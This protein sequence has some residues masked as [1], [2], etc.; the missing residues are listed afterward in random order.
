LLRNDPAARYPE[1]GRQQVSGLFNLGMGGVARAATWFYDDPGLLDRIAAW[2][3]V[4]LGAG[5]FLLL[6]LTGTYLGG[7][8][9]GLGAC[10]VFLLFPGTSLDR[11]LLGF[12]DQHVL[13]ILLMLGSITGLVAS[14]N[15]TRTWVPALLALPFAAFFHAWLGAP[16]YIGPMALAVLAWAMTGTVQRTDLLPGARNMA[17]YFGT[18][19]IIQAVVI[20]FLPDGVMAWGTD[21]EFWVMG[22][23]VVMALIPIVY[24]RTT[25]ALATRLSHPAWPRIQALTILVVVGVAMWLFFTRTA[26]GQFF[27]SQ[28]TYIRGADVAEQGDVAWVDVWRRFGTPGVLAAMALPVVWFAERDPGQRIVRMMCSAFGLAVVGIWVQT[29][30]FD[31]APPIL[32]SLLSV[33]AADTLFRRVLDINRFRGRRATRAVLVLA[34]AGLLFPFGLTWPTWATAEHT[35]TYVRHKA[36]WFDAMQWMARETPAELDYGVMSLWDD[37]NFIAYRGERPAVLSRFPDS[38]D[39]LWLTAPTEEASLEP[40]CPTCEGD[41]HVRYAVVTAETASTLYLAKA[42]A[43]GRPPALQI[44][45]H[46]QIGEARVPRVTYGPAYQDALIRRLVLENGMGLHMYDPVWASPQKAIVFSWNPP[47]STAMTLRHLPVD[48]PA[49]RTLAGALSGRPV[50]PFDGGFAYDATI[51]PQ[52]MIFRIH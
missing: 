14:V 49:G 23:M 50:V 27:W 36:A 45:G 41:E 51:V 15:A 28:V 42:I 16:L 19:A 48:E 10:L 31:Y 33:L 18:V 47:A 40:L 9:V 20:V 12:A 38:R 30:D 2:T 4:V 29:H 21:T 25:G 1:E 3:P 13:E 24:A 5:A 46:W 39:A 22:G 34:A 35:A 26:S 11:T 8:F 32:V 37:G 43:A 44:V 17:V 52:V 6:F 7:A